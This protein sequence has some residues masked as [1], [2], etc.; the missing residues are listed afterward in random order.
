[1][2]QAYMDPRAKQNIVQNR[3]LVD[4][5]DKLSDEEQRA[6]V[7]RARD[8]MRMAGFGLVTGALNFAV[9][10]PIG[11]AVAA[12][13]VYFAQTLGWTAIVP[14]FVWIA[15]ILALFGLRA[16]ADKLPTTVLIFILVT[17]PGALAAILRY[18]VD[19]NSLLPQ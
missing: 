12:A 1:M 13:S 4:K 11:I 5:L 14:S 10:I 9:T 18:A 8:A 19:N 17:I 15:A 3:P 2:L 16:L 7:K 6:Y